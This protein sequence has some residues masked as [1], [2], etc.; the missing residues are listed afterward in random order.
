MGATF[1]I[2]LV[3]QVIVLIYGVNLIFK[4]EKERPSESTIPATDQDVEVY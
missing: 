1:W 4:V 3:V 2:L